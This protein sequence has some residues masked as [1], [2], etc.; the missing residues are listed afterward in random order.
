[1]GSAPYRC[2]C[3]T[4]AI[5]SRKPQHCSRKETNEMIPGQPE[6]GQGYQATFPACVSHRNQMDRSQDLI[7]V[8]QLGDHFGSF[9]PHTRALESLTWQNTMF[10]E[11]FCQPQGTASDTATFLSSNSVQHDS[12]AQYTSHEPMPM[13]L[14]L[15]NIFN[16]IGNSSGI[17][18]QR[19]WGGW[20][21]ITD[22]LNHTRRETHE[23]SPG[24]GKISY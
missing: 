18:P 23:A 7:S 20:L 6:F 24:E 12:Q 5:S 4:H 9:I 15:N 11:N 22:Y 10:D 17:D 1:M 3:L 21:D 2:S 13:D 14:H 19:N 8:D 16:V